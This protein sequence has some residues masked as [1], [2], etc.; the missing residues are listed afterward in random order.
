MKNPKKILI[1]EDSSVIQNLIAR[2]LRMQS[3]DVSMAK[4]GET[5]LDLFKKNEYDLVFMDLNIPKVD[6]MECV[7]TIR[8]M[9]DKKKA[10]TPIIAITGNAFNFSVGDF[11]ALGFND[12]V[13]KPI[14]FDQ[15]MVS[16][17]QQIEPHR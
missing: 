2:I 4:D 12:Y 17:K 5:A 16:L 11:K 13:A 10:G 3:Y 1:T 9:E 15:M 14:D 6:G 8:Q 7:R